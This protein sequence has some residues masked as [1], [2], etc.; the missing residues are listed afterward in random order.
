MIRRA[1]EADIPTILDMGAK[2]CDLAGWSDIAD[3]DPETTET[4]LRGM[5]ASE[6]GIL[7]VAETDKVIGMAGGVMSP[8]YFNAAHRMG[9]E[10]FYWIEPGQRNGIGG[11]LLTA[12][13]DEA[14]AGGCKS[15]IMV[16]LDKMRPE[17]TG[18]MYRA[19]GYRPAEHNWIRNL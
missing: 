12:L 10:L 1:T 19:R 2:F 11:E 4:M 7:L 14:R 17:A 15:W 18:R 16:A 8:L 9:Q 6:D 5:I 13:E 3:F